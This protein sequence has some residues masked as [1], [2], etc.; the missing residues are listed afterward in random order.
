MHDE[1]TG[2][3]ALRR[4]LRAEAP[5]AAQGGDGEA[6]REAADGA[7]VSVGRGA[8]AG[9]GLEMP[10]GEVECVFYAA[11]AGRIRYHPARGVLFVFEDADGMWKVEIEGEG[12]AGLAR[13][14]RLC[15]RDSVHP[16]GPVRSINISA[17]TPPR[18]RA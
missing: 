9:V 6:R 15:R 4:Q 11:I 17:Y 7:G 10:S 2:L 14:L 18:P 1:G 5:G 16:G 12:L 3:D 13:D 8:L